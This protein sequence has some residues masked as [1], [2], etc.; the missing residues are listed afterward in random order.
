MT[1]GTGVPGFGS[2]SLKYTDVLSK[3]VSISLIIIL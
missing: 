2:M 3:F 1:A